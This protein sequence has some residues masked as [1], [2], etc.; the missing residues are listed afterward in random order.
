MVKNIL[1]TVDGSIY[2]RAVLQQVM[3]LALK[4]DAMVRFLSIV[5]VR[6]FEWS[7]SVGADGFMPMMPATAAYQ[8]EAQKVLEEKAEEV[9]KTCA[10]EAGQAGIRYVTR[11]ISGSPVEVICEQARMADLIIMGR[12]GEYA[13]WGHKLMGATLDGTVRQANKPVFVQ[14]QQYRPI[15][16]MLLAYDRSPQASHGLQIAADLAARLQCPLVILAVDEDHN[17]GQRTI[18]EALQYLQA[19]ELETS[20]KILGGKAGNAI[21]QACESEEA[22]LV[23][24]GV[25]GHAR[26]WEALLGCTAEEVLRRID[27]PLL[28][29]R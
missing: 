26:L 27:L 24:M 3:Q 28:L 7:V 11:K 6:I 2:S 5:D 1:A 12:R 14:P 17:S 20:A 10:R 4:Y 19:Y 18:D 15:E 13:R 16:K 8:K 21:L 29:V 22:D 25:H 9:L 23:I